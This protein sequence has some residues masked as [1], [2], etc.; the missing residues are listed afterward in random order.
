MNYINQTATELFDKIRSRFE[1]VTLAD[2]NGKITIKPN[3]AHFFEFDHPQHGSVVISLIDEGKLKIYYA[4]N[5]L[6]EISEEDQDKWYDFLKEMSKFAVRNQLDYEVKNINKERLDKK[7]FLYLKSKDDVMES[8]LYGSRQKSYQ[9]IN[10][11]KMIIVH[12]KSVDEEK[13][14]SRSRNVKSIYIENTEG[15]RYK[16]PNTYLPGA[17]AMTMHVSNGGIPT[18]DIGKH[19]IETMKEMQEL[20]TFVRGIK[21]ENYITEE[22]QDI[23]S[24]A[25]ARYYGLKDTLESMSR[26]K[27]YTNYFTN[28]EP[29]AIEVDENDINDLKAKL[30][31]SVY[32]E[33]LTDT[34]SS[35]SRAVKLR[36]E[37]DA[38]EP[39][40]TN[41]TIRKA[42]GSMDFDA[43]A[44]RTKAQKDAEAEQDKERADTD[45]GVIQDA[46]KGTLEY[47]SN[48]LEK[49]DMIDFIKVTKAMD[50]PQ[51]EKN[52]ALINK[53]KD[54]LALTLVDDQLAA[55][56]AR[57]DVGNKADKK[58]AV[59]VVNKFFKDSKEVQP[60]AKKD[61]YGKPKESIDVFEK[62]M[63]RIVEGTWQ[64]P[65]DKEKLDK[66]TDAMK[67]PIPFGK[68]GDTATTAIQPFIGDDSLYDALYLQSTKQGED[69]DARPVIVDWM[70][71]NVDLIAGNS[72][73][74]DQDLVDA[75][76][77]MVK[78]SG[79]EG[80]L[81][82]FD[83]HMEEGEEDT[84]EG[85]ESMNESEENI[86]VVEPETAQTEPVE[87]TAPVEGDA[88]LQ[89]IRDMAGIGSNAKS[90]FGIRPGEE[91]YQ[92]TPR[93]IIQRQRQALDKIANMEPEATQ[94]AN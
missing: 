23:I 87:E 71:D 83:K 25:T 63:D 4:D 21:K 70:V 31:R 39:D 88:E 64:I 60:K 24:A 34:L 12:N 11:A 53:V 1:N 77:Q 3:Q 68:E 90:N 91:G 37:K 94:E 17:R 27:G 54:F 20:R 13:M 84:Q 30:T 57:L 8:K 7:D 76:R 50:M 29:N 74:D 51:A 79:K 2:E 78:I 59:D 16:F 61:L 9:N 14:G 69:A 33:K 65:D 45:A 86:E 38:M 44:A 46:I 82:N 18:D 48:P 55:A 49:A 52:N 66:L 15:E 81:G 80:D 28:W 19:I 26:P 73:L 62:S 75:V 47:H 72:D 22:Q 58:I 35:V 6:S 67:N 10:N 93:S 43:M 42:D 32:D 92:T 89:K 56:V 85:I 41:P 40:E 5:D 36:T